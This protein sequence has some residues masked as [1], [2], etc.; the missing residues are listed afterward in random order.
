[1]S[2]FDGQ[3]RAGDQSPFGTGD[4]RATAPVAI[5][6]ASAGTA[7][8]RPIDRG[9]QGKPWRIL[10]IVLLVLGCVLAPI[11]VTAAWAKNLVVDQNAYLAAVEPLITDPVIV[12]AAGDPDGVRDRR[13]HQQ[14]ATGRQDR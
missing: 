5:G 13:R 6:P 11:G 10:T 14:S 3:T 8:G 2:G 4:R 9:P 12:Q 1:M 7:R